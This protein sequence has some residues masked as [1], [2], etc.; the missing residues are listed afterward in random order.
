MGCLQVIFGLV[1]TAAGLPSSYVHTEIPAEPY[2]HQEVAA[3]PYIH[4]E[5][6][7]DIPAEPYVHVDIPAEPYVH[8]E[9]ASSN[10]GPVWSG[11]CLNNLGQNVECRQSFWQECNRPQDQEVLAVVLRNDLMVTK[12]TDNRNDI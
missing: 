9:P 5:P 3:M 6:Y 2:V 1:A 12:T 7:Q 11:L 8:I 4:D 10:S